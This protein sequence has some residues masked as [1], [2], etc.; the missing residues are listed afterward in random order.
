MS[1]K[2]YKRVFIL[3]GVLILLVGLVYIINI[4][5]ENNN[6]DKNNIIYQEKNANIFENID[7][8]SSWVVYWDLNIDKE[9]NA[10]NNKLS[11]ISYFAVNF[12]QN[13]NLV[14]PE[15]L[16]E[17][18]DKTKS[19]NY[20]KY[21]TIVN[22]IVNDD[23]TSLLK[24]K[25]I[26]NSLLNDKLSRAKHIDE[27]IDLAKKYEF[28]GIEIDYEQIKDDLY[29]WGNFILFINEL[30][31]QALDN[32][33]KLRV[34][35]EPN[36]PIDRLNFMEGPTYVMMCY[37]LHG[38]FSEPGEKSNQ[39]FIE[40]LIDKM[41]DVPGE[42]VFAIATGGFDWQDNGNTKSVSEIEAKQILL[43]NNIEAKRDDKSKYLYFSYTDKENIK[44]EVWYAD[45]TTLEYLSN[46]IVEAGHE[47]SLWRLGGNL[48]N[49]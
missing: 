7:N 21:I 8:I 6:S 12:N 28:D 47:V 35:L 2:K 27:I 20:E 32:N 34:I 45:Q 13:N 18:Y 16:K 40:E 30:Y 1:N 48:F 37:N 39:E 19:N 41:K 24:D 25:Y 5:K 46:V 14:I 38:G 42:K 43:E 26:L 4:L 9:I 3:I 36:A 10:L 49:K 15:K 44:H 17:Y 23:G 29:L 33:L 31:N 11:S 22:D